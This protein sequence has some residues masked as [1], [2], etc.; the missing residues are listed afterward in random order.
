MSFPSAAADLE[1]RERSDENGETARTMKTKKVAARFT[2]GWLLDRDQRSEL[3]DRFSPAYPDTIADHVT[4][5]SGSD[6]KTPPADTDGEIV[7]HI[8]DGAGVQ[9]LV[10]RINGTTDRPDGSTYHITWSIDRGK[11]RKPVQSNDV[12]KKLGWRALPEPISIT[13]KGAHL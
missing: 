11:G 4:L 5:S 9:A 2:V 10:V 3:L 1:P 8:D 6:A 7:G 12:I 13:L